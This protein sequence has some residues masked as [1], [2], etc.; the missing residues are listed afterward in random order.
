MYLYYAEALI[1]NNKISEGLDQINKV[2]ARPSVN[3]PPLSASDQTDARVKLRHERRVELN[4]EGIR[5]F[6]L[7]RWGIL[8]DVFGEGTATSPSHKVLMIWGDNSTYK[9]TQCQFPKNYVLPIPYLNHS[10]WE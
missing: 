9:D 6:D 4:M 3:M 1:E 5:V 7:L 10:F 8:K 2:R